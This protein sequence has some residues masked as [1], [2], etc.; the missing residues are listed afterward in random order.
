MSGTREGIQVVNLP[1]GGGI[2]EAARKE[3]VEP[4]S[5]LLTLENLAHEKRGAPSKTLGFE[6]LTLDEIGGTTRSVGRRLLARADELGVIT[7]HQVAAYSPQADGWALRDYVPE[8]TSRRYTVPTVPLGDKTSAATGFDVCYSSGYYVVV[9]SLRTAATTTKYYATVLDATTLGVV[10]APTELDSYSGIALGQVKVAA[11]N[12]RAM[13]IYQSGAN[14]LKLRRIDLT[15]KTTIAS[16]WQAAQT[17]ATDYVALNSCF[18]ACS[19]SITSAA[20]IVAVVYANN[21]GGANGVTLKAITAAGTVSQ[22]QTFNSGGVAEYCSCNGDVADTLWV[23]WNEGSNVRVCGVD[24]VTIT[25]T[26]ATTATIL[27]TIS[28]TPK[29][30]AVVV[31]STAGKAIVVA[32]NGSGTANGTFAWCPIQTSAGACATDGSS[33]VV[34][35]LFLVVRPWAFDGRYFCGVMYDVASTLAVPTLLAIDITDSNLPLRPVS[36]NRIKSFDPAG[37]PMHHGVPGSNLIA[38]GGYTDRTQGTISFELVKLD[39]ADAT[40]WVPTAL[41]RTAYLPCGV[42]SYYEGVRVPEIGFLT[43][44]QTPVTTDS[45]SAGNPNGSYRH[46]AL[47]EQVSDTGEV[48]WSAP[49]DPSAALSVASKKINVVVRNLRVTNRHSVSNA[50]G[51]PRTVLYRTANG[52]SLY[53]RLPNDSASSVTHPIENDPNGASF[54]YVDDVS[55]AT[56]TSQARLYREPIAAGAPQGPPLQ[57]LAPPSLYCMWQHG[58]RLMG[59]GEDGITVWASSA[60]VPGEGVWFNDAMQY[61]VEGDGFNVAGWY[62]DGRSVIAKESA[63]YVIEGDGPPDTGGSGNEFSLPR[64]LPVEVGCI[65]PRSIVTTAEGT[66]FQSRRG[67]ELLGPKLFVQ[68]VGEAVR[69]TL[70][71]F[72]VITAAVLDVEGARVVFTC[73]ASESA[74][75]A[76]GTGVLLVFD[77]A[78]RAW[79]VDKHFSSQVMQSACMATV[80]GKPRLHTLAPGGTVYRERLASDGSAFLDTSTWR[81]AVL[82]T[83][84]LKLAGLQGYKRIRRATVLCDKRTNHD[85]RLEI[86]FDYETSFTESKTWTAAQINALPREQLQHPLKRRKVMA[87]KFRITDITPSG[88]LA[89]STGEGPIILGLALEVVVVKKGIARLGATAKA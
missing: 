10:V 32:S 51:R 14:T 65:N 37:P 54:T 64:R 63:L 1:F 87:V 25:I 67:I 16:G 58:D 33:G 86:A 18:D 38:Y 26:L 85:L 82:E 35:D 24:P 71:S 66:F 50:I 44:P 29:S 3:L 89:V 28:G 68:W 84:W 73:A 11:A 31:K 80:S 39:F 22:T 79:H 45:G 48:H 75:A 8:C 30:Q 15:S 78:S 12:N 21:S 60:R 42:P 13:V 56:L 61:P 53:Y 36:N 23:T 2:D 74:G 34:R 43:R 40:R 70:A 6:A 55:D 9:A 7:G 19:T 59:L 20:G 69:D 52:G 77:L 47:Y 57:R 81:T 88:G 46:I 41:G 83:A 27:T 17:I 62:Q 5:A 72:P 76:S 4:G 49:S